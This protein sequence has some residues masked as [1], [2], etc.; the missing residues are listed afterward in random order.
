M[1]PFP[2]RDQ[3]PALVIVPCAEPTV[4]QFSRPKRFLLVPQLLRS[5][6]SLCPLILLQDTCIQVQVFGYAASL[7]P[8]G[9][10]ARIRLFSCEVLMFERRNPFLLHLKNSS[11]TQLV[12][13]LQQM[14]F[15]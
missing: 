12:Q 6:Q 8:Y 5:Q 14:C 9:V 1:P 2:R 7:Y 13:Y 10:V 4:A 15:G 3:D 11:S